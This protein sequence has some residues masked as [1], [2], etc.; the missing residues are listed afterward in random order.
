[1]TVGTNNNIYIRL[2]L[3]TSTI[4]VSIPMKSLFSCHA[5]HPLQVFQTFACEPFP[6][7]NKHYLRA[8][9]RIECYTATHIAYRTYAAVMIFVCELMAG[10]VCANW[11]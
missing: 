11:E 6:E 1:M 10:C 9:Q 8:D 4:V 5:S 7:I 3:C 2:Y